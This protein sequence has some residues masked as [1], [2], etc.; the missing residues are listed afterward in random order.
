MNVVI[1]SVPNQGPVNCLLFG[2]WAVLQWCEYICIWRRWLSQA[3]PSLA[4]IPPRGLSVEIQQQWRKLVLWQPLL[5][6][7][8]LLQSLAF[9]RV[10]T[11]LQTITCTAIFQK[12]RQTNPLQENVLWMLVMC[13]TRTTG[14]VDVVYVNI[15]TWYVAWKDGRNRKGWAVVS[16]PGTRVDGYSC[17]E[18]R[19]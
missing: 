9:Y 1:L 6:W 10:R 2:P 7:D 13:L 8:V 18:Q 4:L 15:V 12:C 16:R 11:L 19:S 3:R 14:V 17:R 5:I